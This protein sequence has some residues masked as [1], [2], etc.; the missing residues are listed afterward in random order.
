MRV[1][2]IGGTN[3]IGPQVVKRLLDSGHEVSVFH[4]GDNEGQLTEEGIGNQAKHIHGDR[5]RLGDFVGEFKSVRPD[6]VIDMY[7]M[8]E[9]DALTLMSSF[10]GV[11]GRI[12][13]ISSMD[14]Y[15]AYGKLTGF[16][17]GE[18]DGSLLREDSPLRNRLYPYR[19]RAKSEDDL[20][21]EYD[22][23]PIE[24]SIMSEPDLA[25]TVLRLPFVYGPGD[26]SHRLFDYLKRMDDGRPAILL[27]QVKYDFRWT[28]GYVED[29]AQAIVLAATDPRA[30]NCI[31][32]V[33]EPNAMTEAEWAGAIAKA[34]GWSGRVIQV[35]ADSVAESLMPANLKEPYDFRNHLAADTSRIRTGLGYL[36]EVSHE[37]GLKRTVEWER[38]NPP[39]EI[40]PKRFDYGAEDAV[41]RALTEI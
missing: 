14:V 6:V 22:K 31:Y 4:R 2:V 23:I 41:I 27:G 24:R 3:F 28:R 16:E 21:Y 29:V 32:N 13:A 19:A 26:Y 17:P 36:E 18:P 37:E 8:F 25:G 40:D 34:A 35:P 10:K 30:V 9:Q 38:S 1:L 15:L 39:G 5:A 12:V 7:L 11:A 33:G 20:L